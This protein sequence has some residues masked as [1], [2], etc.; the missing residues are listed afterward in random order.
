M[1]ARIIDTVMFARWRGGWAKRSSGQAH[2]RCARCSGF[3]FSVHAS[4][5]K[6][7][8][9]GSWSARL[10]ARLSAPMARPQPRT[11]PP[12]APA[13]RSAEDSRKVT[14]LSLRGLTAAEA[15]W[16]KQ[17]E[18]ARWVIRG[19]RRRRLRRSPRRRRRRGRGTSSSISRATG[20]ARVAS[21]HGT[22]WQM[23][24]WHCPPLAHRAG[25]C[26]F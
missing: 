3:S 11:R 12:G 5:R 18:A 14:A 16:L 8:G 26:P 13:F 9:V 19:R 1:I 24:A 23:G 15:S 20:H 25:H 6:R 10:S 21:S 17:P 4:R 7:L 2:V 22:T